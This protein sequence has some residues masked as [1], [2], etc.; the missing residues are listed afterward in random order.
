MEEFENAFASLEG[1]E[2][3]NKELDPLSYNPKDYPEANVMVDYILRNSHRKPKRIDIGKLSKNGL[4]KEE[5]MENYLA[6]KSLSSSAIKEVLKNPAS[7]FFYLNDRA[8]FTKKE[9]KHFELGTFAHLA[10]LEPDLF[11]SVQVEPKANL[12][13]NADL[14]KLIRFYEQLNKSG[15]TCLDGFKQ[16]DLKIHLAELRSVCPFQIIQEDH[17]L[18]IDIVAKNYYRYGGGIIPMILKGGK[19]ETSFYAKDEATQLPVKVRPDY[20]NIEENIGVNAVIS[21]KTTSAN[22]IGKF[23]YDAAKYQYELSEGMYQEVISNV[24]GRKFNCTIMIM[25]QTVPPF[26]PAVFWWNPE[27]IQNGKYK[28]R[29]AL[30]TIKDCQDQGIFPGFEALAESG[31]FGIIN[32]QLPEWS[33]KLIQPIDISE[34]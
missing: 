24:T 11:K 6:D 28:F 5:P 16:E 13:K 4:I 30:D 12:A 15:Q 9:P 8:N 26:L 3:I 31:N 19:A 22:N 34:D 20:F 29:Y 25:L 1:A 33:K 14:C 2:V 17:K 21:F 27:D 32:M 18:I 7:F 10:F 23:I